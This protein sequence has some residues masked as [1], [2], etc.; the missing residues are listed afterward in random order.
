MSISRGQNMHELRVSLIKILR[1][2]GKQ[3]RRA[4][5][6]RAS[7]G[8]AVFWQGNYLYQGGLRVFHLVSSGLLVNIGDGGSTRTR[9]DS[10]ACR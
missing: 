9:L 8:L 7:E 5:Y 4:Q 3:K 10:A 6:T 1:Y 2:K